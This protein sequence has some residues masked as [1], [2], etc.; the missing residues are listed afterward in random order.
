M[1][2]LDSLRQSALAADDDPFES[3]ESSAVRRQEVD[4]GKIFGLN[5]VERMFLSIG[6]F[7]V[8]AVLS[9]LLL[10]LTSSITI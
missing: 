8:V 5:A 2:D 7:F 9:F 1:S 4:E 3:W 6:L 10:L